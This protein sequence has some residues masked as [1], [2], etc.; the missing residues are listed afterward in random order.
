M[1]KSSAVA[2]VAALAA[3]SIAVAALGAGATTAG[4]SNPVKLSGTVS[5]KGTGT[6]TGG[7]IA[8]QTTDFAFSPT[9]VKVPSGVTS[10]TVKLTNPSQHQHTFTVPSQNIDQV[11]APGQ[12][13]TVTVTVPAKSAV[14]FYCRFHRMLGMQGAFFSKKGAKVQGASAAAASGGATSPTTAKS[15][16]S[17]SGYGY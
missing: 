4:K 12:S 16:S 15:A 2:A 5:V 13:A 8:I 3:V 14:L 6:A 10:V 7:N 11:L 1:R 17:G 9:F